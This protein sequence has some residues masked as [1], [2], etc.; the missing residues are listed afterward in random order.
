MVALL[1]PQRLTEVVDVGASLLDEAP[2]YKSMLAGGW[3][4]VTGFE[5]QRDELEKLRAASGPN[6]RYLPHALGDGKRHQLHL[7]AFPGMTSILRPNPAWTSMFDKIRAN[8]KVVR[9]VP[10]STR[11]LDDVAEIE[12]MDFL[13]IDIQGA[14][15]M[16]F[17]HGR[18]KLANCLV[19]QCEVAFVELYKGQPTYADIAQELARHGLRL[20]SIPKAKRFVMAASVKGFYNQHPSQQLIDADA[21]FVRD[22]SRLDELDDEQ[23]RHF[24]LIMHHVYS[25][26]DIAFHC[27]AELAR[28]KAAPETALKDYATAP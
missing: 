9:S 10:V 5:P 13:K 17:E 7:C 3:C 16:V 25:A 11:R 24:A 2:V 18:S 22:Y 12:H 21:V 20:F 19:V 26:R 15:L 28:R 1:K 23:L 8:A 14:E 27:V 6:E 4:R